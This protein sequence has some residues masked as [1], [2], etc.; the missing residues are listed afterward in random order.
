MKNY[1]VL[2][3]IFIF[4]FGVIGQI[5]IDYAFSYPGILPASYLE[6]SNPTSPQLDPNKIHIVILGD[7]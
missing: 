1:F 2:I 7:G 5:E 4:E 6:S 3:L